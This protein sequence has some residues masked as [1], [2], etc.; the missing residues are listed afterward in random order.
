VLQPVKIKNG[1]L[2]DGGVLN[3]LPISR[4]TRTEGDLLVAV[5][6]NADIPLDKPRVTKED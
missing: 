1:L 5:N 3:N 4:V 6:V 2:I